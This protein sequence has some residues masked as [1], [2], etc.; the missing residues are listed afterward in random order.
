MR[1]EPAGRFALR[2]FRERPQYSFVSGHA[3]LAFT[4]AS[5]LCVHR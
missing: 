5:T 3:A 4:A 2:G 1:Q